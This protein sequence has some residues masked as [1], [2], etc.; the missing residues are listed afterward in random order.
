MIQ[1]EIAGPDTPETYDIIP[2]YIRFM[3]DEVLNSCVQAPDNQIGG[4][5][6]SDLQ[7]M[8]NWIIA[9]ETNLDDNFRTC[10]P[11]LSFSLSSA[12]QSDFDTSDH[13]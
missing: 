11:T 12:S 10:H 7:V 5:A 2:D 1:V 9:E 13:L 8:N 4:F 6:T 3:A